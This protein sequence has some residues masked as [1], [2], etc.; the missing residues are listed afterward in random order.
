MIRRDGPG[1]RSLRFGASASAWFSLVRSGLCYALVMFRFGRAA[2]LRWCLVGFRLAGMGRPCVRLFGKICSG[3]S[4][5]KHGVNPTSRKVLKILGFGL[6]ASTKFRVAYRRAQPVWLSKMGCFGP[7][8][9][10]SRPEKVYV[11]TRT[12]TRRNPVRHSSGGPSGC[13]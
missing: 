13:A 2:A 5:R 3:G 7:P 10:T 1:M 11:A 9:F 8:M 12:S 6:Q 4:K